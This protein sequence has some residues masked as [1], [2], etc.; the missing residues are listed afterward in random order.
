MADEMA[1]RRSDECSSPRFVAPSNV[2]EW[3][4]EE[5]VNWVA[6]VCGLEEVSW[7]FLSQG[8]DGKALA[9]MDGAAMTKLGIRG[10]ATRV[11]LNK[12][13]KQLL[14]DARNTQGDV[15]LLRKS[16]SSPVT[17]PR[18][19]IRTSSGSELPNRQ[20]RDGRV[21]RMRS[22]FSCAD[23]IQR[24]P[25]EPVCPLIADELYIDFC[26]DGT[27]VRGEMFSRDALE[28]S[29]M[30]AW[31]RKLFPVLE[32]EPVLLV[33][34]DCSRG[35]ADSMQLRTAAAMHFLNANDWRVPLEITVVRALVGRRGRRSAAARAVPSP[36]PL[37]MSPPP[38]HEK[39]NM[40]GAP[41]ARSSGSV[42]S[43][44]SDSSDLP[45]AVDAVPP[46]GD[47]AR[48]GDVS[49]WSD[50]GEE[51]YAHEELESAADDFPQNVLDGNDGE[52]EE[53]DEGPVISRT[54][55]RRV[56]IL[57]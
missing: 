34:A 18:C 57:G 56:G 47:I 50:S 27:W 55:R 26:Y 20:Q 49:E 8:V 46:L 33:T 29:S 7:S 10:F 53:D 17:S 9:E 44:R 43:V 35:V 25:S 12:H 38:A 41:V 31:V 2:V 42:G 45:A 30:I 52:D 19:G 36:S 22:S 40:D 15:L 51:Y 5:V 6:S 48:V 23:R 11:R 24:T 16:V 14:K 28:L 21:Q 4:T 54:L 13:I 32:G 39:E 1:L 3:T 37:R